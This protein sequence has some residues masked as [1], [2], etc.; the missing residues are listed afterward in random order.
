M[1]DGPNEASVFMVGGH[2]TCPGAGRNVII[3]RTAGSP[4]S[5]LKEGEAGL[6]ACRF[7]DCPPRL[8]SP[9]SPSP[10]VTRVS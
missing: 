8:L 2:P 6:S 7:P 9:P 3:L 1:Q 5:G 10:P 4:N